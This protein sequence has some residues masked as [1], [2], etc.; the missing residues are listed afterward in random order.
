[1][2]II[3]YHERILS[4]LSNIH[5]IQLLTAVTNLP[6]C[7]CEVFFVSFHRFAY[8]L[9]YFTLSAAELQL[10]KYAVYT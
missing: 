1:M 10:S 2:S 3:L 8:N 5:Q 9:W 4:F 6:V 7:G